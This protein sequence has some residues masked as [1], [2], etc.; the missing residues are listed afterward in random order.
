MR[1]LDP[2][3]SATRTKGSSEIVMN[4]SR[5]LIKGLITK[6]NL[7]A[8]KLLLIFSALYMVGALAR[9]PQSSEL[10]SSRIFVAASRE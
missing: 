10:L 1:L 7:M 8:Q 4:L 6:E 2:Y 9:F 5:V 3:P